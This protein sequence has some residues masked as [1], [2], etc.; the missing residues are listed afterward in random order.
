M[1]LEVYCPLQCFTTW[2]RINISFFKNDCY[3]S[4]VKTSDP[5]LFSVWRFLITE[6]IT[7]AIIK[8]F[9]IFVSSWFS[10]ESR[11]YVS[12]NLSIFARLPTVWHIVVYSSLLWAYVLLWYQLSCLLFIDSFI[13]VF[14]F[15]YIVLLKFCQF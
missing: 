6:L 9:Q 1:S 10:L 7:L 15:S 12:R 2:R 14:F 13:W 11:P 4:P 3:N 5:G 8:L